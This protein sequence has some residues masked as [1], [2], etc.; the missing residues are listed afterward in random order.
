MLD[1]GCWILDPSAHP[2][3][4]SVFRWNL[5]SGEVPAVRRSGPRHLSFS[6]KSLKGHASPTPQRQEEMQNRCATGTSAGENSGNDESSLSEVAGFSAATGDSIACRSAGMPRLLSPA[7]QEPLC[8][9]ASLRGWVE[10]WLCVFSG[11]WE[12]F[13]SLA[14]WR[15]SPDPGGRRSVRS[16]P[17]SSCRGG[18]A[19][20]HRW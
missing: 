3:T 1:A 19:R 18:R 12:G 11:G 7:Q 5:C 16:T 2:S 13:A 10:G 8:A 20:R 14:S 4:Q 17:S 6:L 15:F 9:F